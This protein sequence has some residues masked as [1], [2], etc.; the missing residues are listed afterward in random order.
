MGCPRLQPSSGNEHYPPKCRTRTHKLSQWVPHMWLLATNKA[1]L[2]N[3]TMGGTKVEL[4]ASPELDNDEEVRDGDIIS[5][6]DHEGRMK[7]VS[8]S[9]P[10]PNAERHIPRAWKTVDRVLD[11]KMFVPLSEQTGKKG[12][13]KGQLRKRVESVDPEDES[14]RSEAYERGEEPSA[15]Y[16]EDIDSWEK[17]TGE[18][19][20]ARHAD[21]VIW[22][23]F[24]WDD[25]GYDE[26]A[27]LCQFLVVEAKHHILQ[28]HGMPL[29]VKKTQGTMLTSVLSIGSSSLVESPSPK[30]PN[31]RS[32]SLTGIA[33]FG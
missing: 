6:E 5:E 4:L 18:E 19:L 2:K 22:A 24:K 26:G 27:C 33:S 11:I 8:W 29:L 3:F 17:R 1:K 15:T 16:M 31:R 10:L 14:Q 13:N 32:E 9:D 12:K 21:L 30:A 28:R 20:A 25:L 23:F 7:A